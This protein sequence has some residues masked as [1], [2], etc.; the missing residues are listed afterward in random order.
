[1]PDLRW[2]LA[3]VSEAVTGDVR[4]EVISQHS[5]ENSRPHEG[6]WVFQYTVRITNLGRETVQLM[7]RHWIITDGAGHTEEVRGPGVVGQQPVLAPGESFKYSSWCPLKT[8][9]GMMRGTYQMVRPDGSCFDIEI[10]PFALK[11]RY[12]VQ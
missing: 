8:P 3:P 1:M 5:A 11:A 9:M 10:A 2:D 12:T 6:Q 7:S 4:V